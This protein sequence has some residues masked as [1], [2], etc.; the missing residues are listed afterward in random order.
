M[1]NNM[2]DPTTNKNLK[3]GKFEPGSSAEGIRDFSGGAA[4]FKEGPIAENSNESSI[5]MEGFYGLPKNIDLSEGLG[6]KEK[7]QFEHC[8]SSGSG[9]QSGG[10]GSNWDNK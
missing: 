5:V 6:Q 1:R 8:D 7:M 4:Q 10:Q 9:D 2:S 3:A